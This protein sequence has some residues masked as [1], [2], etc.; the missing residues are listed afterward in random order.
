MK[1]VDVN[2]L[3]YAVN[4]RDPRNE[5]VRLWWEA[6]LIAQEPVGVC[7]AVF[8]GFLRIITNPRAISHPLPL[9]DAVAEINGWLAHPNVQL[10]SESADHWTTLSRLVSDTGATGNLITDAHL[11]ALAIRNGCTLVSCDTDFARFPGL[12][13]LNPLLA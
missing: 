10:V 8:T 5:K 9:A 6:A 7:W 12:R 4:R 2:I 1:L 13:W 3:V 11:A